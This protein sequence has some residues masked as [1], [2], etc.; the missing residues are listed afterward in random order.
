MTGAARHVV[1]AGGDTLILWAE[2][3]G[4]RG[5][6]EPGRGGLRFAF[7]GRVSTEDYQ[8]P[9][10]SRA[11]QRDQAAALVA[12][13]GLIV[14]EFFD[15]GWS[16]VLPWARRPQ[17]AA[18]LAAMADPD[19]EFDAIVIGEY[20]RAFY[21]SQYALMAPL[22]EHYGVQLWMPEAGGRVNFHSEGD[23]QMMTA[24]GCSPS[25]RSPAPGSGCAP[26]WPRRPASRAATSAAAR[27]MGTGWPTPG[28]TRTRRT[29]RGAGGRSDWSRTRRPLRW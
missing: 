17:A 21:G 29:R 3:S 27:R 1:R 5:A 10:T 23:E 13:F 4:R 26:R 11:R 24:L 15:V 12:G 22:F 9:V 7:Y 20:E 19:R 28:R 16:R 14:A 2:R 6:S 25:G 8:D 18:L